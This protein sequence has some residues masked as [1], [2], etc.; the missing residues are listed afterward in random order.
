MAADDLAG[1]WRGLDT[2]KDAEAALRDALAPLIETYGAA[3]ATLAADWYD[4]SRDEVSARGRFF[5]I[6]AEIE[7][8]GAQALVG[9]ALTEAQDVSGFQGLVEGGAQRRIANFARLTVSRSSIADP[10][11]RGW[12]RV[13][14]GGCAFCRMLIG[15]GA[16]YSEDSA[17][18]QSHDHCNCAAVPA[19][20]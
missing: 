19:W 9:W 11:A 6:P 20:R 17:D 8:V 16:V 15:R 1:F 7:D 4:D 13:G 10:S 12:Q 14:T 18:F 5:A 2:P 3:A